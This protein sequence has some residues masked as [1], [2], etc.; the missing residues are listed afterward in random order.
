MK[1]L[2]YLLLSPDLLF[3][4]SMRNSSFRE[5]KCSGRIA[6]SP[7]T[8]H[9]KRISAKLMSADGRSNVIEIMY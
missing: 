6:A 4:T 3:R 5:I 9:R 1:R 8:C 7:E 2:S